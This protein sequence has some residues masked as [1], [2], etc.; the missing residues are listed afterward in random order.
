MCSNEYNLSINDKHRLS[1]APTSVMDWLFKAAFCRDKTCPTRHHELKSPSVSSLLLL[2]LLLFLFFSSSS[3]FFFLF[4]FLL[5]LSL[6]LFLYHFCRYKGVKADKEYQASVL[7][8]LATALSESEDR[9]QGLRR[10]EA[11]R[12]GAHSREMQR[13]RARCVT[14]EQQGQAAALACKG[15]QARCAMLTSQA[16][17][18]IP[19]RF[20]T[21]LILSVVE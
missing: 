13:E 9:V 19:C 6:L 20:S 11:V 12:A 14:S 3:F 18:V 15:L 5:F 16:E 17:Q 4:F 10:G 21:V 2:L 1:F 7:R 8:Q